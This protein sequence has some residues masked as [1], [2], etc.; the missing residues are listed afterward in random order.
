MAAVAN[1]IRRSRAGLSDPNRPI[2]SFLFLG[3]DRRR[4]DRAGPHAGR[5]P[6][7]RRAGHGAHR[8][9]R[10][11]GEALGVPPDRRPAGLR[12]ATRRAAS[13]PRRC[14]AGPTRSCSSTRSRRPIPTCSTC[15]CRCSTTAASPTARAAPV[16]FTNTVL[17][18]TS[19]YPGDVRGALQARVPQ[20]RRRDR[21]FPVADPGRHRRDR[22]HPAPGP[23]PPPGQRRLE[24]EVT[25]EAHAW[26]AAHGYDPAYGARPLKRL[27]QREIGD[28][29]ALALL[30][31]RYAE[32]STVTVDVA[33]E[34]LVLK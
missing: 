32:G 3:P 22:R 17:I 33:G 24:L 19:N 6:V 23:S 29:L 26:L 8:H 27:I 2:G 18:M 34:D 20:P 12:R 5:V 15:C 13:S 11:H 31:G 16:D 4:Q 9:E 7:R 28:P 25:P 1:A 21:A 14:G 30:E 10:V